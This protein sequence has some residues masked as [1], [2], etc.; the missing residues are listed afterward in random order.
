MNESALKAG[1]GCGHDGPAL[2]LEQARARILEQVEPVA[3]HERL[4]LLDA[5]GRILAEPVSAAIDVPN[6]TNSAMDGYA[7]RAADLVEPDAKLRQVG[8]SF[9][10]HPYDGRVG[11]GEC[12][13]IMTGAVLPDGA[14]SVVMQERTERE[15]DLVRFQ[16]ACKSGAN[17]RAAGEDVAR[18][19]TVL[20]PGRRIGAADLG[21]LASVGAAEI[22]VLPRPRVA[23]FSTGDEIVPV[24]QPLA[25]GKIHD[26]NR[27]TLFGLLSEL[28]VEIHDLGI[29]PVGQPLAPGKIHDSNRHTL[30]GLLSELGV[31]IHDLGIVPDEPEALDEA[32]QRASEFD[33]VLTTGGVSVGAAD[34][35]LEAL[36]KAGSVGF[37]QVAMKPGRPLAFGR[38]EQALFFG[39]PGNPVSAMVTFIQ[40]VRPALVKLAGARPAPAL[41]FD[42]P[43]RHAIRKKAGR[44]EF[45]RGRLVSGEHGL[46][47]EPFGHQGSGVLRSMSRADCLINLAP[48]QG[49]VE[50]G[51]RVTVEPFA[52]PIWNGD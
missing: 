27:H 8:E 51:A 46:E 31:E 37:W 12:V 14:D 32:L 10:G 15:D 28:G 22:D 44:R 50:A 34:Y 26:S 33:A 35:V 1:A 21:V 49:N 29:V 42:V 16:E 45:Q 47:V 43:T 48:N 7:V 40:L 23:F 11:A 38:L 5:L 39:L 4:N 41:A 20:E 25:P 2:P 52:Q 19:Q 17:V 9:A 3:G 13:R 30:F 36:E 18:G 24:G 6:H